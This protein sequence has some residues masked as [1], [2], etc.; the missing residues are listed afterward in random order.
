M[1]SV[2]TLVTFLLECRNCAWSWGCV[3]VSIGCVFNFWSNIPDQITSAAR[4]ITFF[5]SRYFTTNPAAI[6]HSWGLV[7]GWLSIRILE[8]EHGNSETGGPVSRTFSHTDHDCTFY[9]MKQYCRLFYEG[10]IILFCL[11][12][13]MFENVHSKTFFRESLLWAPEWLSQLSICLRLRS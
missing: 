8:L 10:L 5:I 1:G 3:S 12:V 7:R 4:K 13:H 2:K 11:L 9:D 6:V